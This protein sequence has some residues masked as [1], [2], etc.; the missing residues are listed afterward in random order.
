MSL[1]SFCIVG[2]RDRKQILYTGAEIQHYH[3]ALS[4]VREFKSDVLTLG[5]FQIN[6]ARFIISTAIQT[7][8]NIAK[9]KV[10]FVTSYPFT[11]FQIVIVYYLFEDL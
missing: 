5:N 1:F 7:L 8:V 9:Q 10:I 6:Y 4:S 11:F 3:L 2:F